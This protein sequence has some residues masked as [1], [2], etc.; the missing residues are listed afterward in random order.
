[1]APPVDEAW[2]WLV[3]SSQT[4][5]ACSRSGLDSLVPKPHVLFP[6]SQRVNGEALARGARYPTDSTFFAATLVHEF[7]TSYSVPAAPHSPVDNDP[8]KRLYVPWRDDP[9]RLP[10]GPGVYAFLGRHGRS[11]ARSRYRCR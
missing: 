1:M 3:M 9:G 7:N 8:R 6:E 11:G 10:C 5:P 2:Q 4:M